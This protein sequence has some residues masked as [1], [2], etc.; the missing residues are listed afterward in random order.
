MLEFEKLLGKAKSRNELLADFKNTKENW[1][2][3]QAKFPLFLLLM[4]IIFLYSP[5][6]KRNGALLFLL[7]MS[8]V[9]EI[10]ISRIFI[11]KKLQILYELEINRDLE[12]EST[13][14]NQP[15]V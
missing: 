7:F 12:N 3:K 11:E 15:K 6:E 8:A 2:W 9:I 4:V 10:I 1:Y 5:D 14:K 13:A